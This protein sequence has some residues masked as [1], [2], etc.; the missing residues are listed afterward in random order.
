MIEFYLNELIAQG[1]SH[2]PRWTPAPVREEDPRAQAVPR[3]APLEAASPS[4]PPSLA[5]E[6]V[7]TDGK[8]GVS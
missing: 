6:T 2:I 1:T 3:D 5:T 7:G 8:F 4:S